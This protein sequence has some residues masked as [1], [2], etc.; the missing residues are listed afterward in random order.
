MDNENKPESAPE[1]RREARLQ[2]IFKVSFSSVQE[3]VEQYT[4]NISRGGMFV[5]SNF[6]PPKDVAVEVQMF[7]SESEPPI[8]AVGR[9]AHIVDE[10]LAQKTGQPMGFGVEFIRFSDEDRD[11][12]EKYVNALIESA[13][14]NKS[15]G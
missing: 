7:V 5:V 12:F 4:E 11:R 15:L 10:P 1:R 8:L 13:G 14:L 2:R 9:V 3:L 6:Q